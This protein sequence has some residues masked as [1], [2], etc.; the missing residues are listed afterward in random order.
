MFRHAVNDTLGKVVSV[1]V[2]RTIIDDNLSTF[3]KIQLIQQRVN[4]YLTKLGIR[5]EYDTISVGSD[6]QNFSSNNN[7]FYL[8]M[9]RVKDQSGTHL[10]VFERISEYRAPSSIDPIECMIKIC[11][12]M[13]TGVYEKNSD[14]SY[15]TFVKF[16]NTNNKSIV[17]RGNEIMGNLFS[18]YDISLS[19][20]RV[21]KD[22]KPA[23][24]ITVDDQGLPGVALSGI[25]VE[26]YKFPHPEYAI[27]DFIPVTA[28]IPGLGEF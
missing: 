17:K 6:N 15:D 12:K 19:Y 5:N 25:L 28:S 20:H 8:V 7:G 27:V 14:P 9:V 4:D 13:V 3:A 26:G 10:H 18:E 2:S 21:T 16:L 23:Y 24:H 11:S 1:A 22:N